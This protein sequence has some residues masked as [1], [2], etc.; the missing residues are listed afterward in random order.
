MAAQFPEEPTRQQRRAARQLIEAL[1]HVYPCGEC[2]GHFAEVL[3]QEPPGRR[4][5]SREELVNYVCDVHNIV[6][7]SLGK[8]EFD[9][10]LAP[11]RWGRLNCEESA[12]DLQGLGSAIVEPPPQQHSSAPPAIGSSTPWPPGKA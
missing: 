1:A 2:A 3:R 6:N 9:C 11:L 7:R 12:C 5:R 10:S 8:P 4:V